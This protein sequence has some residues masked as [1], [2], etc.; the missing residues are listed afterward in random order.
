MKQSSCF[1]LLATAGPNALV[2]VA[3]AVAATTTT[4]A[5]VAVAA[6]VINIIFAIVHT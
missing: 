5:T 1:V 2:L 6:V 4:T 3:A